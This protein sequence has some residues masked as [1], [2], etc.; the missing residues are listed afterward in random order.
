MKDHGLSVVLTGTL[1]MTPWAA[2]AAAEAGSQLRPW[3]EYRTILWVG[4]SASKQPDKLPLF[5]QR[6]REMG[7]NTAMVYGDADPQ[8][9]L[10]N[11]FPY[12]VENII[13]RGLCLK[14]NSKVSDWDKFVTEWAKTGRP[15]AALVRDYCLYDPAWL[16]WARQQMQAVARSSQAS[17]LVDACRWLGLASDGLELASSLCWAPSSPAWP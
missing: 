13:N 2:G 14:W 12:Y 1:L 4:D 6:Q 5:F 16:G 8:P 3:R 10:A 17:W 7:I 15:D 9:L 11:Y